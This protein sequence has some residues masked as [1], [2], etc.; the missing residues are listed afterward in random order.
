MDGKA[1]TPAAA[2]LF[3]INTENPK[4][5]D[6]ERKDL[7][8]HLVMQGICLSQRGRPD[9]RTAI[10]FLHSCLKRPDKDD[11]KKLTRLIRYLQHTLHM[12]LILGK[13]DTDIVHWWIDASYAVHPDMRGHTGATMSLGNR[14][15]FSGSWK[16]KLVTRRVRL[17]GCLTCYPR[18]YGQRSS[19][20][21]KG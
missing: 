12:C 8:V 9:I 1:A 15:V 14:S 16:Q 6:K 21:T 5:L 3:K 4:P 10:S 11:Y 20:R 2:H 17:W 13:D 18:S 7:F 19:W